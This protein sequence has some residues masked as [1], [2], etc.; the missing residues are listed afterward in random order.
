MRIALCSFV[1][2]TTVAVPAFAQSSVD[3]PGAAAAKL[4]KG[5][6]A[7]NFRLP[8]VAGELSGEVELSEVNADGAVVVVVLRGYPGYQCPACSAQVADLIKHADQ[9]AAKNAR[10]LLIYPGAKTQL[11]QHADEFLHGT[12]L[13]KPF[14][15]LLDPGY[16]FTNAYGLR[17][18]A[19][20]ETAYPSTI[21]VD[22]SGKI[23]FVKVSNSHRGRV[24]ATDVLAAL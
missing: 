16:E 3:N 6:P 4:Q 7:Q 2:A 21:V 5:E 18:D 23:T 15:F 13:P 24:S 22:E 8:A 10:V 9:F 12:K 20:R 1:L 17:W 14:T 11:A 19:P